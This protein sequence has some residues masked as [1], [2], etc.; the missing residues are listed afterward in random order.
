[1]KP[2][3]TEIE[4][5]L[6]ALYQALA[7]GEDCPP[8]VQLRIEGLMEGAVISGECVQDAIDAL[9]ATCYQRTTGKALSITFGEDWRVFYPFPQIPV[10]ASRAPVFPTTSE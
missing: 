2:L 5:R 7:Q 1:M 6:L 4:M 8:G 9:L 10:R 3:Q